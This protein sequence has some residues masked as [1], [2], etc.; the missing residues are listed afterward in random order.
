[1]ITVADPLPQ[2]PQRDQGELILSCGFIIRQDLHRELRG[3]NQGVVIRPTKLD[4]HRIRA[5]GLGRARENVITLTAVGSQFNTLRQPTDFDL[6]GS[7]QKPMK[8]TCHL[9]T[10]IANLHTGQ[11]ALRTPSLHAVL[12]LLGVRNDKSDGS[13]A[14]FQAIGHGGAD[15]NRI[16]ARTR[17]CSCK[18]RQVM[19]ICALLHQFD[20][21][22]QLTH[23][24]HAVRQAIPEVVARA[25]AQNHNHALITQRLPHRES[26]PQPNL[27]VIL[28]SGLKGNRKP[29]QQS[30]RENQRR[31]NQA[32]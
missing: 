5:R 18:S 29:R 10:C 15:L 1:M 21:R 26:S 13:A 25:G 17:W 6:H 23:H 28:R 12:A 16:G 3:G 30:C 7:A 24:V 2:R 32:K 8:V 22:R 27:D 20:A 31:R 14:G 4:A 9:Q 19:K 11:Q